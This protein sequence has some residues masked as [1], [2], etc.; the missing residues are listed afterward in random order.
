MLNRIGFTINDM[1]QRLGKL[2]ILYPL[3][4]LTEFIQMGLVIGLHLDLARLPYALCT[5][6]ILRRNRERIAILGIDQQAALQFITNISGM[7]HLQPVF[8]A[9]MAA[10]VNPRPVVYAQHMVAFAPSQCFMAGRHHRFRQ[11]FGRHFFIAQKTPQSLRVR[12]RTGPVRQCFYARRQLCRAV[13]V[14]HHQSLVALFQA[15]FEFQK[16]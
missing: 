9:G 11:T 10:I 1:D 16:S 7:R 12:K 3:H 4:A 15:R 8:F 5:H 6:Q 13:A 2:P 14:C